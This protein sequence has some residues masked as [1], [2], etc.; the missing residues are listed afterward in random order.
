MYS[1]QKEITDSL[2]LVS[3]LMSQLH[4]VCGKRQKV[5][6]IC[7]VI[8][9]GEELVWICLDRVCVEV[10]GAVCWW[11]VFVSRQTCSFACFFLLVEFLWYNIGFSCCASNRIDRSTNVQNLFERSL[12]LSRVSSVWIL[13]LNFLPFSRFVQ[14]FF[15]FCACAV[16]VAVSGNDALLAKFSKLWTSFCVPRDADRQPRQCCFLHV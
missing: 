3:L 10:R 11:N 5:C 12:S 8:G 1:D 7:C 13:V 14:C 6:V 15:E 16:V 4:V 2:L 9:C